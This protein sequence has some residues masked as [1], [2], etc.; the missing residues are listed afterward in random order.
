MVWWN[1]D[2]KPE[3]DGIELNAQSLVESLMAQVEGERVLFKC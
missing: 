1:L 2:Q 3:T